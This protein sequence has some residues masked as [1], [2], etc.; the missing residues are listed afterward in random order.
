[1]SL[2][3]VWIGKWLKQDRIHCTEDRRAGA[4][5]QRQG[6]RSDQGKAWIADQLTCGVVQ[7]S[8]QRMKRMLPTVGA[9]LFTDRGG[10]A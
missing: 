6:E 1:M 8:E 4:D 5:A 2:P 3:G 9:D 7:V 10:A